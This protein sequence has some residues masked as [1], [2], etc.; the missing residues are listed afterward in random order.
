M[1]VLVTGGSGFIGN[2]LVRSLSR[3][4]HKVRCLVRKTGNSIS[5]KKLGAELWFGDLTDKKSLND[6]TKG[7]DIVFHLAAIGDINAI[8]KN[9]YDAYRSVNIKGTKNLLEECAK[10][11]IKK[12]VHFS[13]VAAMGNLKKR[14]LISEKGKCDPQTPYEMSKYESE[15]I[16]L[17]FWKKHKVPVVILR[18]TMVYGKGERKEANKIEKSVMLRIVPILGDGRNLIDM[19]HVSDIVRATIL[20][21]KRGRPG[22]IYIISGERCTWNETVDLIAQKMGIE[23]LKVHVPIFLARPLVALLELTSE[24]FNFIPPFTSR[25]L[26]SL[27]INNSYDFSKAEKEL[28]YKPI[29]KFSHAKCK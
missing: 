14:G 11:R 12:F 6:I 26:Q 27:S 7:I 3:K 16:A 25:R 15:L 18:P 13:S 5:L 4:N 29:I 24:I 19:V 20:A 28:G 17:K 22:E 8:S 23:I 21:A 10:H 1:R 9:Y 2:H